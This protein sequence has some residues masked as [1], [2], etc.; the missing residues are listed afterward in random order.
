VDGFV[1]ADIID[2]VLE[3]I[4][5]DINYLIKIPVFKKYYEGKK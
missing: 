4:N 1:N 2:D 3:M 5:L